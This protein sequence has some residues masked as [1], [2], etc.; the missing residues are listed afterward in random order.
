ME[1]LKSPIFSNKSI[2]GVFTGVF[3][4]GDSGNPRRSLPSVL[5]KVAGRPLRSSVPFLMVSWLVVV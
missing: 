1:I 5:F 2:L 4:Q 3:N